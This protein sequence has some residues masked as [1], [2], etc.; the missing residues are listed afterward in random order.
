MS[1]HAHAP[2]LGAPDTPGSVLARSGRRVVAVTGGCLLGLA[3]IA[4]ALNVRGAQGMSGMVMGLGQVGGRM[5]NDVA[6]PLFLAMWLTMMVAMM[7]PTIAP[8]VLAHR[9]VVGRRGEGVGTTVAFVLGYLIVWTVIGVVPMA[10]LLA[11]RGLPAEAA[12]PPWLPAVSGAVLVVA[13]L[14]QLTPWK[15]ACLRACR[16]PL[17]FVIGHDFESGGR[18]ALR[19]GLWHGAFCLGCCWALMSVLVVVGLMNLA[20]M[21]VLA[22]VFLA[23]KNWRHGVALSRIAGMAVAAVGVAVV[24]HPALLLMVSGGAGPGK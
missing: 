13:G 12:A 20:W 23:E 4:W 2:E 3:A 14:Y 9:L 18:G 22:V 6:A 17:A 7:F 19:A 11:L 16:S 21:A 24:V 8:M 15:G 10:V 1:H 5:P